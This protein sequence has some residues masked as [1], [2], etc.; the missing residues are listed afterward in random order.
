MTLTRRSL[1]TLTSGLAALTVAGGWANAATTSPDPAAPADTIKDFALG[2]PDA[3]VKIVEYLS[4]TCPHCEHFHAEVFPKLKADYIDTGKVLIEYHEVYFDRM[5][6]LGA[7]LARCGG[8]MRY[9]GLTDMLYDKQRDW[10]AAESIDAAVV[11]L[12]KFA[13]AAGMA[14]AD[15][16]VCLHDQKMAEAL[17]AH[18][19]ANIAKDYPGDT[20]KG[21][22]SFIINGAQ[23]ANMPYDEMKKIIDAELAK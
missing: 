4:F 12:K 7:M 2:S 11:E 8:E 1:L 15:V 21:T 18:Y 17:V 19:Q 20:F 6:L 23:Y 10:A 9:F 3:K 16:D 22:P 14:D 5:G 13:R